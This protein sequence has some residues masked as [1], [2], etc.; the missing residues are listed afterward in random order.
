ML[1]IK[2]FINVNY[3]KYGIKCVWINIYEICDWYLLLWNSCLF[4]YVYEKLLKRKIINI[5][6]VF[7]NICISLCLKFGICEDKNGILIYV[8]G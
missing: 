5:L 8:L 3:C 6:I 1:W 4:I 2:V 7:Y